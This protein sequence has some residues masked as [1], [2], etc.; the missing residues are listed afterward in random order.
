M[1]PESIQSLDGNTAQEAISRSSRFLIGVATATIVLQ[2]IAHELLPLPLVSGSD[3]LTTGGHLRIWIIIGLGESKT[4]AILLLASWVGQQLKCRFPA[5]SE[6]AKWT[7]W[8]IAVLG[9]ALFV[10]GLQTQWLPIRFFGGCIVAAIIQGYLTN[11]STPTNR[12]TSELA[13]TCVAFAL[14]FIGLYG[15]ERHRWI[16]IFAMM[17]FCYYMLRLSYDTC[18]Q[19]LMEKPWA[20]PTI[21]VL[22]VLSFLCVVFLLVRC[23]CGDWLSFYYLVPVWAVLLQPV[24]VYPLILKRRKKDKSDDRV[25]LPFS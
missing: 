23:L 12:R 10:Y 22:S 4:L 9:L 1:R 6:V 14:L 15:I 17:P 16:R 24:V 8:I 7:L 5:P 3:T 25:S 13:L 11:H 19:R 18:V 21:S 2:Y 20:K